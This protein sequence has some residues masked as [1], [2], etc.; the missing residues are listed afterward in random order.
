MAT[1]KCSYVQTDVLTNKRKE[2]TESL[3]ARNFECIGILNLVVVK[4]STLIPITSVPTGS[5][6]C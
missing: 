5:E 1:Q 6:F 4:G 2:K 3:P